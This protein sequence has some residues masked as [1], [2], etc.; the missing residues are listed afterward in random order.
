[1]KTTSKI[2]SKRNLRLSIYLGIRS[3]DS[4]ANLCKK[5]NLQDN[6]IQYYLNNM[7]SNGLIE[8]TG[9]GVWS[10]KKPWEEPQK[11]TQVTPEKL[12]VD[13]LRLL[14]DMVRGH[15]FMFRIKLPKL[16]NWDKRELFFEKENLAFKKLNIPGGGQSFVYKGKKIWVTS[17]SLIIF[18][19]SSYLANTAA[20]AKSSA[21]FDLQRILIDL[22]NL[23]HA[24]FKL[25]G[26]YKFKVSRQHYALVKNALAKQYD[27]EGKR[28]NIYSENGLWFVIDNSF[29]LHEAETI[30]PESADL[31]NK[32]VQDFFNGI[33]KFENFTPE[34]VVNSIAGVSEN[35]ALYARN[36]E[37]HIS[38][39]QALGI[40][41][42]KQTALLE[43]LKRLFTKG[44]K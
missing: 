28:L 44:G 17:K 7:R 41:V 23:F 10:I 1:M 32:K 37:S 9:Y 21:I 40:G 35:Q 25:G 14:P 13:N 29:N 3:G 19:K 5:L 33:K 36:I 15:A 16:N 26:Q 18:E 11:S 24:N 43:E 38:A 8:K 42:E 12:R 27:Q 39:I 34:F 6:A 22:E 20:L 4:P 31:D 30:H 2:N